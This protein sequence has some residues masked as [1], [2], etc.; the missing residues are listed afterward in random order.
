MRAPATH[1]IDVDSLPSHAAREGGGKGAALHRLARAGFRVPRF[2]IL[3]ASA[4]RR[5]MTSDVEDAIRAQVAS[6]AGAPC[7]V[8]SSAIDEDGEGAS[9]AGLHDTF[10]FVRTADAAV[11]AVR[12]VWASA[13][14]ERALSYRRE[15]NLPPPHG[16]AVVLQEMIDA[17]A[18]AVV[19]TCDPLN[20]DPTRIVVNAA[21]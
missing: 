20:G 13:A 21:L 8:R 6:F 11:G 1:F 9:F 7:A 15:R 16:I 10:L 19:F 18:S 4:S 17:D 5:E 12:A 14:S 2:A 3:P